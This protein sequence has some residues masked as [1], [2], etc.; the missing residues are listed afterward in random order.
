MI[1]ALVAAALQSPLSPADFF[2]MEAGMK[3][4]YESSGDQTGVYEQSIGAPV[5]Y[6]GRTLAPLL[7]L[8]NGKVVAKTFYEST[9]TGLYILGQDPGKQFD[10]PQPVFQFDPKGVKWS[11]DG[12]SP[13]DDDKGSGMRMSGESRLIGE[14]EFLGAKHL[15]LEMKTDTLIGPT[16]EVS[17]Q[18]KQTMVFAK[19]VGMVAMEQSARFGRRNTK[20]KVKILKFEKTG[21]TD[22]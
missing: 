14:R 13:Y 22:R 15:C 8:S 9:P 16:S 6:A 11:F 20:F 1:L 5:A 2:P 17:T 10:K 21:A 19:G 4:T 7:T 12:P 3:W 18:F